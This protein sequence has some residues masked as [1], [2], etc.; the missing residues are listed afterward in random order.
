MTT[1]NTIVD[2]L[3]ISLQ[4]DVTALPLGREDQQRV[5]NIIFEA[6]RTVADHLTKDNDAAITAMTKALAVLK[7]LPDPV[8]KDALD[9]IAALNGSLGNE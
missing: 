7:G 4:R 2:E 3:T 6:L 9:A 8:S 1:L 5:V